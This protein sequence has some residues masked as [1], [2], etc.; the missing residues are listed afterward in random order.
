MGDRARA[1]IR[2]GGVAFG[3]GV[4][5]LVAA[6]ALVVVLTCAG[7]EP[8]R[9]HTPRAL[10]EERLRAEVAVA[11]DLGFARFQDV[12]LRTRDESHVIELGPGECFAAVA[13]AWGSHRIEW[14]VAGEGRRA[15]DV[16]EQR[17][18]AM[19]SHVPGVVA[20]IQAC[21]FG[22]GPV[23]VRIGS[24]ASWLAGDDPAPFGTLVILR[25]AAERVR[26]RL[27]RGYVRSG[28]G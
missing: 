3:S 1:L 17:G 23:T 14:I 28:T 24:N 13:S 12:V 11:E 7:F 27:N 22:A 18:L 8:T 26:D 6:Y 21:P 4:V 25:A 10:S 20:H 2:W 5:A 19:Q 9:T 15:P 16:H